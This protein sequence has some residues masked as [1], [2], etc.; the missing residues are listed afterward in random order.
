MF[1]TS[2]NGRDRSAD[3]TLADFWGYKNAGIA[4]PDG[5][6]GLSLMLG[7]T[8]KGISAINRINGDSFKVF[9]VD[10]RYAEYVFSRQRDNADSGYEKAK[11]NE[12]M[13]SIYGI[14]YS[15]TIRKFNLST[16]WHKIFI[17]N[18]KVRIKKLIGRI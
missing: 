16:K 3:I 14:G 6:K 11:R 7:F 5:I 8:E 4:I 1:C 12:L 17:F 10:N 9:K 13:T 18:L 15:K 2:C